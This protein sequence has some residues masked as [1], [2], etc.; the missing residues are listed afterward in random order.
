MLAAHEHHACTCVRM[1]LF[2]SVRAQGRGVGAHNGGCCVCSSHAGQR[3]SAGGH[4]GKGANLAEG[5]SASTGSAPN[6][7]RLLRS[8][9][10]SKGSHSSKG[11]RGGRGLLHCSGSSSDSDLASSSKFSFKMREKLQALDADRAPHADQDAGGGSGSNSQ[12]GRAAAHVH[13]STAGSW[14]AG[15]SPLG[16]PSGPNMPCV[17]APPALAG[18]MQHINDGT[19]PVHESP[20]SPS[21]ES[22]AVATAKKVPLG[23]PASPFATSPSPFAAGAASVSCFSTAASRRSSEQPHS[24]MASAAAAAVAA[25][26]AEHAA[27]AGAMGG[28]QGASSTWRSKPSS[29]SGA[30]AQSASRMGRS[31]GGEKVAELMLNAGV[32]GCD[33]DVGDVGA[34]GHPRLRVST[35]REAWGSGKVSPQ[36]SVEAQACLYP[37]NQVAA[38]ALLQHGE[39]CGGEEVQ[40]GPAEVSPLP[41]PKLCATP[42]RTNGVAAGPRP[43]FRGADMSSYQIQRAYEIEASRAS[44]P[45]M[46]LRAHKQDISGGY[47]SGSSSIRS[48][49]SYAMAN[50]IQAQIDALELRDAQQQQQQQQHVQGGRLEGESRLLR[51]ASHSGGSTG[52]AAAAQQRSGSDMLVGLDGQQQVRHQTQQV[53]A[54]R[55]SEV[56]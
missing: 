43:P 14:A 45:E 40:Y 11:S 28:S 3:K 26:D 7:P 6:S 18:D 29:S 17:A 27:A 49:S 8:T 53:H 4:R 52:S 41:S 37:A 44:V 47:S 23:S 55:A 13:A 50:A 21:H 33:G 48:P 42:M 24:S 22:P 15:A 9:R 36:G 54:R 25:V 46:L 5:G 12:R 19:S 20:T 30:T 51:R 2:I 32:D 34:G 31:T 38:A 35:G 39:Q 56:G 16:R 10:D 1:M